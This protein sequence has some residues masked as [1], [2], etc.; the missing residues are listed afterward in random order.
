MLNNFIVILKQQATIEL[1]RNH[2]KHPFD[3]RSH[4]Q[5]AT[6]LHTVEPGYNDTSL[7]DTSRIKSEILWYQLIRKG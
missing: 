5:S 6:L 3:I 4:E 7:Y 1:H 2:T